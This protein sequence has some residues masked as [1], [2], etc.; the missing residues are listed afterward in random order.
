MV[1]NLYPP[2]NL[3]GFGLCLQ[4][5]AEGLEERGHAVMVLSSDQPYLG[6][7]GASQ[8]VQRGLQLLGSYEG[9]LS[10]L[11]E[12]PERQH[13]I[14]H[15]RD[16]IAL[17][18]QH[19]QPD[20]ALVGNL[21]L[22]GVETLHQLLDA[23][24]PCVQHVGF[25]GP[26]FP[27]NQFP[28][29]HQARYGMACASGEVKRTLL[30]LGFPVA[31]APVVYPP[32]ALGM[33]R[34]QLCQGSDGEEPLRVGYCGLLMASK[35]VHRLLEAAASLRQQGTSV[36]L[37]IAGKAFSIE[38]QQQLQRFAQTAGLHNQ[39]NWLG[40]LEPE[41]LSTFYGKLDLLV[42]PSIYPESFGMVV[43]EAMA[44]GVVPISTGVGG[45]FEVITHGRNG[46]LIEP[47]DAG[48]L[49][50]ALRHAATL[51]RSALRQLGKR[52]QH[53]AQVRYS[54][55]RSVDELERWLL[56]HPKQ[57]STISESVMT[58]NK[59]TTISATLN[60]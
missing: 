31:E 53:D 30:K 46:W 57:S 54:Q 55:T 29:S 48:S 20:A 32:L 33:D 60:I 39:V 5:L 26:P 18:I 40:F 14:R 28:W 34:A 8:A 36:Q 7:G 43:A 42:F 6:A 13:R 45:A 15:N 19:W 25:L 27:L 21:D 4:R 35:G 12:G 17:A 2:Q 44:H 9:G 51:P 47:D 22:L 38:Y 11:P 1:T 23:G 56:K 49:A 24:L 58:T 37:L 10:N 59:V 16:Q 3:G 50:S 41:R 52:A